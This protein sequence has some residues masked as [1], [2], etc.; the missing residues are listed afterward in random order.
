MQMSER[1]HG[2]RLGVLGQIDARLLLLLRREI[3]SL[4]ECLT[5][6]QTTRRND[7]CGLTNTTFSIFQVR[8][9]YKGRE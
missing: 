9:A 3:E 1:T 7:G 2:E 5:L 4:H 6:L 8:K